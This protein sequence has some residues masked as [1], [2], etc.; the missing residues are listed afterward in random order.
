MHRKPFWRLVFLVVCVKEVRMRPKHGVRDVCAISLENSAR[1]LPLRLNYLFIQQPQ[2]FFYLL[3]SKKVFEKSRL[4][5]E[6]HFHSKAKKYW[7]HNSNKICSFYLEKRFVHKEVKEEG[8]NFFTFRRKKK[9]DWSL[10]TLRP[11]TSASRR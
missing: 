6:R 9:I 10:L 4:C 11:Q 3:S 7:Y 1:T 5:Q 2:K 8:N